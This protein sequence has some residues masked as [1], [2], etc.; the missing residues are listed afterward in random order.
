MMMPVTVF[1]SNGY[2]TSLEVRTVP[3]MR[4]GIG[5]GDWGRHPEGDE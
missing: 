5:H 3:V 4:G 2:E 1:K